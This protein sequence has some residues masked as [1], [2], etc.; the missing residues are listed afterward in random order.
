MSCNID[1]NIQ[2]I[3]NIVVEL[4]KTKLM[5]TSDGEMAKT[6]AQM[7]SSVDITKPINVDPKEVKHLTE[8][9]KTQEDAMDQDIKASSTDNVN[10]ISTLMTLLLLFPI[11]YYEKNQRS[12]VLHLSTL[13]DIWSVNCASADLEI[14]MKVSLLCRSLHMRFIGYFSTSSILVSQIHDHS[15]MNCMFIQLFVL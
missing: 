1:C 2:I 11:E 10:K 6:A 15:L 4:F 9:I 13:I 7:I 3:L 8:A 12:Q 14:R 5:E